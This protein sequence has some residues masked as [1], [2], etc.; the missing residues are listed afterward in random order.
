V[1][2]KSRND[3]AKRRTR[4]RA[5]RRMHSIAHFI[6]R[7][8]ITLVRYER[9]RRETRETYGAMRF[10]VAARQSTKNKK[11]QS[12]QNDA[13]SDSVAVSTSRHVCMKRKLKTTQKKTIRRALAVKQ[14]VNSATQ[15]KTIQTQLD[16]QQAAGL[17]TNHAR[18][19]LHGR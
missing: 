6:E 12:Q 10:A 1:R 8:R 19:R 16:A 5:I 15:R 2:R 7:R 3:D 4:K 11:S 13:E 9:K 17:T 14:E 18:R